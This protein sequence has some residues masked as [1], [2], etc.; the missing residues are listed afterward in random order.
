[1]PH[2]SKP[3]DLQPRYSNDQIANML[4]A[5]ATHL[6]EQINAV[7]ADHAGLAGG[8]PAALTW[9]LHADNA[10]ISDLA[11]MLGTSHAGSVQLVSRL[12]DAGLVE[13]KVGTDRRIRTLTLTRKGRSTARRILAERN[14]ITSSTLAHVPD[15]E[16]QAIGRFA[17]T[18]LEL[19][20]TGP[21]EAEHLC[22]MCD[23]P[24]CDDATCP[25]EAAQARNQ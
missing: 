15:N 17:A 7:A 6:A 13:R 25:V 1:M 9:L 23:E 4:G 19:A 22:R 14:Q 11:A 5:A 21:A 10:N 12:S 20:A 2:S 8:G 24:R 18:V 16:R 3:P